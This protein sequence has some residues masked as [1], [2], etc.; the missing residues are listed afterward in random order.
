MNVSMFY[1]F[2]NAG[3]ESHDMSPCDCL[4]V[5]L[6][7]GGCWKSLKL[8]DT[9]PVLVVSVGV[10]WLHKVWCLRLNKLQ[11]GS[12]AP[13]HGGIELFFISVQRKIERLL[14]LVGLEQLD[15]TTLRFVAEDHYHQ[16][17]R[18]L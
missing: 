15:N 8:R 18:Y 6:S 13:R 14:F 10:S 16:Q 12:L 7:C 3:S 11:I 5:Q 1:L 17:L 9:I 4:S 2:Q